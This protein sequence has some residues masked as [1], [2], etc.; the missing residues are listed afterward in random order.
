MTQVATIL[1]RAAPLTDLACDGALGAHHIN[2]NDA[3]G[4][5]QGAQEPGNRGDFIGFLVGGNRPS[6]CREHRGANPA[7]TPVAYLRPLL[8]RG[9]VPPQLR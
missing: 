8:S 9:C 3:A 1:T 7:G 2:G 6:R 4:H 5:V